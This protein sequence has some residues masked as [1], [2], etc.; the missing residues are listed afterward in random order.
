M[1]VEEV[2]T[3]ALVVASCSRRESTAN[4]GERVEGQL[5]Y[6]EHRWA[7]GPT[8]QNPRLAWSLLPLC[9]LDRRASVIGPCRQSFPCGL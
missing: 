1:A 9:G 7:R 2:H 8:H 6:A 4:L 3:D 5:E